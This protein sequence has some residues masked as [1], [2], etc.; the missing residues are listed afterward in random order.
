MNESGAARNWIIAYIAFAGVGLAALIG[1]G[2][3]VG[4]NK[5]PGETQPRQTSTD[6][7]ALFLANCAACHGING[8]GARGPSLVSGPLGMLSEAELR[9]KIANGRR[10]GGMPKFEGVLTEEQIGIVARYV[11]DLREAS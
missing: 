8:A 7:E 2:K 11:I 5:F 1:I 4:A 6:G 9:A 3:I 10:L